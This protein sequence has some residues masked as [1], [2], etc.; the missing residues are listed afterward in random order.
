MMK[1]SMGCD[2][3]HVVRSGCPFASCSQL[4]S[5]QIQEARGRTGCGTEIGFYNCERGY[6]FRQQDWEGEVEPFVGFR[7]GRV[8]QRFG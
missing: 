5:T 3:S 7:A 8:G 2:S 1:S 4:E 6:I